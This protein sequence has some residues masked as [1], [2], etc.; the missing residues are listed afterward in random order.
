MPEPE[1]KALRVVRRKIASVGRRL[2]AAVRKADAVELHKV[3]RDLGNV[4]SSTSYAATA[5]PVTSTPAPTTATTAP[6]PPPGQATVPPEQQI[7]ALVESELGYLFLDRTRIRPMGFAL[8]EHLRTFSLAPGE[9]VTIEERTYSKKES[10]FEES[11]EREQTYD[12]EMSST[13]TTELNEGMN[14]ERSRTNTDTNSMGVNVGG[15]IDGITF[16]VGPTWS[17][18]LQDA[19]RTSTNESL[20]NSQVASSKVAARN[21]SQH[22]VMLRVS[23]P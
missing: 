1:L 21:R 13:L 19:D 3:M 5:G 10:T 22:K 15:N 17:G 4:V 7:V 9:E 20:K 14:R 16:N 18:S 2:D 6:P 23:S 11:S 8:G 12:T